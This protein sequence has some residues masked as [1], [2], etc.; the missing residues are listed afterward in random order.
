[1]ARFRS[2]A[3]ASTLH[4]EGTPG[5]AAEVAAVQRRTMRVLVGVQVVGGLGVGSG[6]AV[7]GLLAAELSGS[8]TLSGLATTMLT[9]G[10]ALLALPL[11]RLALRSGRRVGLGVG[12]AIAASGA[13]LAITAAVVGSFALLIAAMLAFGAGTATNLQSRYAA[14]DLAGDATRARSL[15]VVVWA[16]SAGAVLGPNLTGV[17]ERVADAVGIPPL[18][19]TLV[20][21][22]AAFT[23]SGVL[24][25]LLLRPD[26]LRVA[27]A[28][29]AA[30]A[31]ADSGPVAPPRRL[32]P[33]LRALD[34]RGRL[35]LL[36]IVAGHAVMVMVMTMT[37]VH[38]H[39]A[40]AT[41]S[42]VGLTISLHVAGMYLLSPV[43]GWAA[44][45]F[46]RV[47]VILAGQGILLAA[48]VVS[49]VAGDREAVVMAGLTLLGLGWSAATVAGATLLAESVTPTERPQVQGASDLLMNLAG[50]SGGAVS[51]VVLAQ[52]GYAGL[53]ALAGMLVV[54][55]VLLAWSVRRG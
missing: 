12:W 27:F 52:L 43:A 36:A 34:P 47:P 22:A 35:A 24:I 5:P 48:V 42:V 4:A 23:V 30:A 3:S 1:M 17:G 39:H 28:A 21:S 9:L 51:G 31:S 19:G 40:G 53:N 8:I 10:A 14:T 44:D 38:L 11:A 37:P 55:V 25:A 49:G 2:R 50:A 13:V 33:A 18:A 29:R 41:L 45:R 15:S 7:G 32:V 6:L 54:P 20:F 46:G 26:P 16:T